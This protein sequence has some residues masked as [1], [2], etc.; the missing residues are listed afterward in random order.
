MIY[1]VMNSHKRLI[2]YGCL[3][4]L[5]I[6]GSPDHTLF[7][8]KLNKDPE[9]GLFFGSHLAHFLDLI[10]D[11]KK[12]TDWIQSIKQYPD[13][14]FFGNEAFNFKRNFLMH[15][16]IDSMGIRYFTYNVNRNVNYL[17]VK[18]L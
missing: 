12:K 4:K 10:E 18:N 11:D 9:V 15:V 2:N 8:R 7:N 5:V 6:T 16:S 13:G 14:K 17:M 1:Y 3:S